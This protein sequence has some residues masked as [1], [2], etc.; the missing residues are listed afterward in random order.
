MVFNAV[1][2]LLKDILLVRLCVVATSLR[3]S[4]AFLLFMLRFPA[5]QLEGWAL[6]SEHSGTQDKGMFPGTM[7]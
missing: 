2:E 6:P 4:T 7:A 3:A 5:G 1:Q